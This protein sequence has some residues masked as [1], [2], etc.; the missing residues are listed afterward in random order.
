MAWGSASAGCPRTSTQ[1][2]GSEGE[3]HPARFHSAFLHLSTLIKSVEPDAIAL[4]EAIAGGVPG[5]K[6]RVQLAMGWRALV[7]TI[8]AHRRIR[9]VEYDVRE[10]RKFF[11]GQSKPAPSGRGKAMV[12]DRCRLLK[13][14]TENHNEADACAVW[15]LA[16]FKLAGVLM[17]TPFGLFDG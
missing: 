4:E 2:F 7:M 14:P 11:I 6:S 15:A 3:P 17:P 16:R 8:A 5:K 10:C 13:W 1:T 9:V 12:M